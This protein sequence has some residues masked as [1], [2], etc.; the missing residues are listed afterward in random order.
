MAKL[1]RGDLKQIVKECLVEIL[2]E[3]L[4]GSKNEINESRRLVT[5]V[6]P[7][8]KRTAKRQPAKKKNHDF[9]K[10]V[11]RNVSSLTD[12]PLMASIF[13]DTARG[14]FQ[15]QM[16]DDTAL[17]KASLQETAAPGQDLEEVFGSSASQNWAA[18]AFSEA[19]EKP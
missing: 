7:E 16:T 12:D 8:E 5:A 1:R 15:D 11:T 6:M 4:Q 13:E 17:G 2:T 10:A 9:N 18:L 3:G 14:T 19:S